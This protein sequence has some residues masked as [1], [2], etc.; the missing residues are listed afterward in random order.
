MCTPGGVG[1][2]ILVGVINIPE[3]YLLILFITVQ[4]IE[5]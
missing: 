1:S 2:S 4:E 3:N 5:K